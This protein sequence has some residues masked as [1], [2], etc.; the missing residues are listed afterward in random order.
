MLL[1]VCV[2]KNLALHLTKLIY[3]KWS[4]PNDFLAHSQ[5]SRVF[6]FDSVLEPQDFPHTN[7]TKMEIE[8]LVLALLYQDSPLQLALQ[9]KYCV[10]F[11]WI[12]IVCFDLSKSIVCFVIFASTIL[13]LIVSI[14]Q[15]NKVRYRKK[16][17]NFV[18]QLIWYYTVLLIRFVFTYPI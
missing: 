17:F 9:I 1:N 8:I 11:G 4:K 15:F 13:V 16:F 12:S 5:P 10:L 7:R 14:Y 6:P 2:F 3:K 18:S